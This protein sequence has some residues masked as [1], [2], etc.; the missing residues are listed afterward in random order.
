MILSIILQQLDL[1]NE[2]PGMICLLFKYSLFETCSD[3]EGIR[4]NSQG[5]Y[6]NRVFQSKCP[7]HEGKMR[8]QVIY[9]VE[10]I[11]IRI[12]ISYLMCLILYP[13]WASI[14]FFLLWHIVNQ[15]WV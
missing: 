12:K 4:H 10:N 2:I 1:F 13:I 7:V 5:K 6:Y 8:I 14:L 15:Q 11:K 9:K 3:F